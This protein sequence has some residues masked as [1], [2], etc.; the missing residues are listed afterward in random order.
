MKWNH[1]KLRKKNELNEVNREAI[2]CF[3]DYPDFE[4]ST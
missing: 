4:D 3:G 2:V 1:H